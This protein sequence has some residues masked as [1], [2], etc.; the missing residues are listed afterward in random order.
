[1]RTSDSPSASMRSHARRVSVPKHLPEGERVEGAVSRVTAPHNQP[2]EVLL[3]PCLNTTPAATHPSAC[4]LATHRHLTPPQGAR[5][6][7]LRG[8]VDNSINPSDDD[9]PKASRSRLWSQVRVDFQACEW[10]LVPALRRAPRP[11]VSGGCRIPPPPTDVD[12]LRHTSIETSALLSRM[13]RKLRL[14]AKS[15]KATSRPG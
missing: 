13:Q 15:E 7:H 6:T 5:A 1:M 9:P 12:E 4:P 10:L 14:L 11:S 3:T 2:A 8:G